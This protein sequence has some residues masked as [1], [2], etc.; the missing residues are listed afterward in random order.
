MVFTMEYNN[1]CLVFNSW[2][3]R[4]GGGMA[5]ACIVTFAIAVAYEL[6]RWGIRATDRRIF[7]NEHVLKDSKRKD[8]FLILRA[9]LYAIQVL[10]S[11]FLMLTIMSYN[12][13]IMISLIL[14]AF[15]GFYLFCRDG[16]Q[17]L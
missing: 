4:S 13:Y 1:M 17:G 14:G 8:D 16:I 7:K 15:V 3:V 10:I 6:V 9:I 2:Q 11:F 5:A 12:G